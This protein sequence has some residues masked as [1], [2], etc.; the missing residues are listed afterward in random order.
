MATMLS[1]SLATLL[2]AASAPAQQPA[3]APVQAL[4]VTI[5]STMLAGDA[6]GIG[7]WGFAALLE[8]DGRRLL[9]DTGARPETVFRNAAELGVDLSTVSDAVVGT[10]GASFTLG[11]GLEP[12]L[13]A[14]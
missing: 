7:E 2:L 5:L 4:K 14:R 10:V 11:A 12:L 1:G 8:V 3:S 13:L 9:I 6:G